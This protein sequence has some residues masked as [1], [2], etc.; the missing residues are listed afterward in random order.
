MTE[1]DAIKKIK[2]VSD[3]IIGTKRVVNKFICTAEKLEPICTDASTNEY[4]IYVHFVGGD[5][6]Y[7]DG[8]T[9]LQSF[10]ES[11]SYNQ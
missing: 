2:E 1:E 5:T 7:R 11:P 3:S 6:R 9:T 8:M 10:L 4:D